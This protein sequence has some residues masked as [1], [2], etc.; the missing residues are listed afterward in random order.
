MSNDPT[1]PSNTGDK[2][3]LT[4]AQIEET[5]SSDPRTQAYF[6][7]F[8]PASVEYFVKDYA[9]KKMTW[10]QYGKFYVDQCEEEDTQWIAHAARHLQYIQQKKLFDAQCLWRAEQASYPGVDITFDF[11]KWEEDVLRCPFIEPISEADVA[12]YT[13]Y[14]KSGNADLLDQRFR[15]VEWQEYTRLKRSADDDNSE[16]QFPEWYDYHNTATGS[17]VLL[18]LPNLR[19]TKEQFYLRLYREDWERRQNSPTLGPEESLPWISI[20]EPKMVEGFIKNFDDAITLDYYRAISRYTRHRDVEEE[21][22]NLIT[23]LLKADEPLPMPHHHDFRQAIREAAYQYRCRK[24]AEHLPQAFEEYQLNRA[25]G[26]LPTTGPDRPD[27]LWGNI[28]RIQRE[29][30]IQGRVL[31]GEAGDLEF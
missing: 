16:T 14:L 4:K 29:H 9:R 21:L 20:A 25:L 7:S 22:H 28:C 17:G 18:S 2:P 6:K 3:E 10:H 30:I 24:T 12:L 11:R 31:N 1:Q 19:G 27:D 23:L 5:L 8:N 15:H 13:R 26:I